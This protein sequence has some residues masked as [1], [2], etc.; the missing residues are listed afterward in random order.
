MAALPQRPFPNRPF[1]PSR[2]P[3]DEPPE[4]LEFPVP[5]L[6]DVE[7]V[8]CEL[9]PQVEGAGGPVLRDQAVEGLLEEEGIAHPVVEAP[10]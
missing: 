1:L 6:E 5:V 7:G 3:P 8:V 2:H 10:V 9:Q 4:P